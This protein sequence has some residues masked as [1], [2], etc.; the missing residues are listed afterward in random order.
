MGRTSWERIEEVFERA[1]TLA[2]PEREEFLARECDPALRAEIEGMIA[3][4]SPDRAL[5]IERL[6]PA[7]RPA[8][9]SPDPMVGSELGHWRVTRVLGRGGMGTVYLAERADGQYQQQ[10]ALKVVSSGTWGPTA[11]E[12]FR[13]ERQVLARLAHPNIARLLD[14]GLALDGRPYFVMELV[15]GAPITE[16]CDAH[17]LSVGERLRLFCVVCQAVQHA[18][19]ALVVHRDL[20]P[21]N[22]FVSSEGEVKLLDF[23]IAKLLEPTGP[24]IDAPAT[25]DLSTALT[26]E[27]AAPEQLLGGQVTTATDVYSLGVLLYELLTGVRP[28]LLE[29]RTPV[30]M[31]REL[32]SATVAPPSRRVR[33][34]R[35]GDLDSIVLTA[36]RAQ[37]E[38]RYVSAGQLGEDIARYLDGRPVLARP[39]TLAYRARRFVGRNRTAVG[40][41]GLLA[42]SLAAFGI[43]AGW[44][45][46]RAAEER[47]AARLERDKAEQV[48]GVLVDLFETSNPNVRPD[49]DRITV[50]QFLQDAEPRVLE[51]LS[52]QPVVRARLLQVFGLIYYARDQYTEAQRALEQALDAQRTLLG[53]D[54]PDAIESLYR[55][56]QLFEHMGDEDRARPLFEEAYQRSRRVFGEDHEK[57]AQALAALAS[58]KRFEEGV[59]LL[60][61]ALEIRRRILPPN[62][63]AI[64]ENLSQLA[65]LHAESGRNEDARRLYSL[66]LATF[67]GPA[68]RR[69][70][71]ALEVMNDFAVLLDKL[72]EY[73]E[74][75]TLF[76]ES[77]L[78]ARAVIGPD[79]A[80]VADRIN[81]LAVSLYSEGR[82]E[83][84]ERLFRESY[85]RHSALFGENHWRTVNVAR[86]VGGLL[87]LQR[88][89]AEALLWMDKA[90]ATLRRAPHPEPTMELGM[91]ARRAV[92]LL[93]LG[94][95]EEAL[96]A[97]EAATE[98]VEALKRDDASGARTFVQLFHAVALLETGRPGEAEGP[99]RQ[100][101]ATLDP[102]GLSH[103][104]RAEAECLLGWSL[105]RT[106]RREEGQAALAHSLPLYR[107]WGL[108]DPAIIEAIDRVLS[109]AAPG[110]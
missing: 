77:L 4:A 87:A 69:H 16:W 64:A 13:N 21:A 6:V 17:H 37:P 46:R 65:L 100:A 83:E 107:A 62:H 104:A 2:P 27:Y 49:G 10:A 78:S 81:N 101:L 51:G 99:A 42:A 108:A 63:P 96:R 52:T 85:Q 86:S 22:T 7:D 9:S 79:S 11:A 41:V 74:A 88:R 23:G 82:H 70:P 31:E 95:R 43:A 34:S 36:L 68:E 73:P 50:R 47:D 98:A 5:E 91:L 54:H 29:G 66:A 76:R 44:Q 80:A 14:G 32:Q 75:E 84:A 55:L 97:L 60:E 67:R 93:R 3:A 59:A 38:R 102:L 1:L 45:A 92:I 40:A 30:E 106:G 105:V 39:D 53:P 110:R 15:E 58:P 72:G 109:T 33:V 56:G 94:R 18:H 89:Y 20:K 103:P 90:I 19:G 12:R 8:S 48:A 35:G 71:K 28:R 26:P 25:R 57:T 61:R 24:G